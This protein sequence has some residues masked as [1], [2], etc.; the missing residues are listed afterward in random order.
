MKSRLGLVTL[1]VAVGGIEALSAATHT[2][3][4]VSVAGDVAKVAMNGDLPPPIGAKSEIFFKMAGSDV[5]ITVATGSAL[6]IDYGDLLVK[7]EEASGTVSKGQLVRFGPAAATPTASP[8]GQTQSPLVAASSPP[9]TPT[10]PEAAASYAEGIKKFDAKD[11][12]GSV[13][14]FTKV[15]ELEPAY[16]RGHGCR[17]AAYI[18]LNQTARALADAN[19]AIRL[20]PEYAAAHSSRGTCYV[21]ARKFKQ[22]IQEYD[23]AIRL[24][25]KFA[26]WYY[27]R[28]TVYGMWGKNKLALEDLT[29]AIELNP[30]YEDAYFNRSQAYKLAGKTQLAKHDL[31]RAKELAAAKKP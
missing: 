11:F 2:G 31:A 18:Y 7:I 27:N 14:A 22:A 4:V 19:E 15:I 1:L 12:K 30:D 21:A 6:K 5:E 20:Y 28:G 17:A 29:K 24:E 9:P 26:V 10:S 25:P 3:T 16:A 8:P 13:A 23:E